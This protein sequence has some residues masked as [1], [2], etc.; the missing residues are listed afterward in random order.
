[1]AIFNNWPSLL[2]RSFLRATP[3]IGFGWRVT[4]IDSGSIT[5]K[6]I[7]S[8]SESDVI[9]FWNSETGAKTK[10]SVDSGVSSKSDKLSSS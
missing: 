6:F 4:E 2:P 8:F 7:W 3:T 5:S 1:M 9:R 10:T